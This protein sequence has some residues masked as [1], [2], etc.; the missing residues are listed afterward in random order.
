GI[1]S[2]GYH[3]NFL[4]RPALRLDFGRG[5]HDT[6]ILDPETCSRRGDPGDPRRRRGDVGAVA[7][8]SAEPGGVWRR[9]GRRLPAGRDG[10]RRC[11]H[12]RADDLRSGHDPRLRRP[13]LADRAVLLPGRL[14]RRK[15][16]RL[17]TV[18]VYLIRG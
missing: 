15:G 12:H 8:V 10:R 17:N 18:T 3:W 1:P 4:N 14:V 5:L 16:S 6:P 13:L 9:H 11:R 2:P 7:A